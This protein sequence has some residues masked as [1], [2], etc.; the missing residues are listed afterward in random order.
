MGS[1]TL[2]GFFPVRPEP[3]LV[4]I[5]PALMDVRLTFLAE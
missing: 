1:W 2:E 4:S 3:L 5:S